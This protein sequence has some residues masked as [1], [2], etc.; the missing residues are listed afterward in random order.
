M[1]SSLQRPKNWVIAKENIMKKVLRFVLVTLTLVS[2]TAAFADVG[3]T[4]S[5]TGNRSQAIT[6]PT[7]LTS[8]DSVTNLI[9]TTF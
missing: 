8:D 1:L 5:K 4:G 2:F 3:G 7:D 9:W 6:L